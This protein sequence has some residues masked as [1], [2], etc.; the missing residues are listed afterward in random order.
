M[1]YQNP[2]RVVSP[3][4]RVRN[5]R[6]IYDGGAGDWSAANFLFDHKESMGIRWNGKGSDIGCPQSRGIPTWFLVPDEVA[7]LIKDLVF[8][9][10]SENLGIIEEVR[11]ELASESTIDGFE[12]IAK[13]RA[14]VHD[15]ILTP[16]NVKNLL[17][18]EKGD[19]FDLCSSKRAIVEKLIPIL[20]G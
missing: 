18:E 19:D 20:K 17:L 15:E 10:R 9:I 14:L 7:P 4:K 13:L 11:R 2:K 8:K 1:T 6:V 16:E 3:K 5:V 12:A